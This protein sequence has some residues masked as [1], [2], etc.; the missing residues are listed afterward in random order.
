MVSGVVGRNTH[1]KLD[2]KEFRGFAPV[3]ELAPMIFVSGSDTKA[4]QIFTVAHELVHIWLGESGVDD[5][6][7]AA[8]STNSIERWSN[9]V[10]AEF[11]LPSSELQGVEL[12]PGDLTEDLKRL[13]RRI[14]FSTLVDSGVYA[15]FGTSQRHGFGRSSPRSV[16]GAS[17]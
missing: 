11:L 7:M 9:E 13:A 1:R 16:T 8:A 2:P 14:K 6:D 3:S 12:D 15:T 10:A 5:A 4:A 17:S